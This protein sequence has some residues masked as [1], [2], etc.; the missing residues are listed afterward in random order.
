MSTAFAIVTD[1]SYVLA[2][3]S[4]GVVSDAAL[5]LWCDC[6]TKERTPRCTSCGRCLCKLGV[7]Q[8]RRFW[9]GAPPSMHTR[10]R[11]E[12]RQHSPAVAVAT[13]APLVLL[14]DDDEEIRAIGS[15]VISRLGFRCATATNG[16]EALV[17]MAVEEPA[18]VI[19]DALMPQMDGRELC[20]F[21][22]RS[23]S[24]KVVIMTSLYTAAHYKYEAFKRFGADEYLAKPIDFAALQATLQR[25]APKAEVKA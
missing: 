9:G 20:R 19:T 2:C 22:K 7:E 13:K 18:I 6:L 17:M 12:M 4:C 25:L 11:S 23:S 5:A 21:V 10:R 14:V 1:D 24:A 8:R 16:P 15:H 3:P